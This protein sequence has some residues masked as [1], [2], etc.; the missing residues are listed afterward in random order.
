VTER[1]N[2][3]PPIRVSIGSKQLPVEFRIFNGIVHT[4]QSPE[5]TL[6]RRRKPVLKQCRHAPN[7]K[8]CGHLCGLRR[9]NVSLIDSVDRE[10][11][12][13]DMPT[14]GRGS[15]KFGEQAGRKLDIEAAD[16]ID[17]PVLGW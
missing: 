17:E 16:T 1:S 8:L 6:W 12:G 10:N 2:H 7:G 13:S 14:M 11:R 4:A 5:E 9:E 15:Q 3:L